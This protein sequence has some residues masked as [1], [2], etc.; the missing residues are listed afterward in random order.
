MLSRRQFLGAVP[1]VAG[2]AAA[3]GR[4]DRRSVVERH[5]PSLAEFDVRAPL[6]VGNGE[7]AFT[8]DVTGLQT[9]PA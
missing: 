2:T 9:C 5:N 8:A 3:Q 7:F 4:I 6:S 1:L